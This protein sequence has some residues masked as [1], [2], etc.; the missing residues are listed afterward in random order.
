MLFDR[1][2][3]TQAGSSAENTKLL[4][5]TLN[6]PV[7]SSTGTTVSPGETL[8]VGADRATAVSGEGRLTVDVLLP[9]DANIRVVGGRG[10]KSFWVFGEN[11]DWHWDSGENQPRPTNDFEDVPYGE[12]RLE[13]EPADAA[14]YH[15]FLTVMQPAQ[16]DA[17][18]PC[19]RPRPSQPLGGWWASLLPT[20][21][22][23]GCFSSPRR[24]MA[25]P[26]TEQ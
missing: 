17:M 19:H 10:Q 3:V 16:V 7:V 6:Q 9:L 26:P 5:H 24:R 22:K 14:L 23:T 25:H 12:W 8:Y 1:V 13:I 2:G 18:P 20:P 4:I 21:D 15:N 11:Y